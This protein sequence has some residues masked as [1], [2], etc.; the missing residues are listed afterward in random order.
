[1]EAK[2]ILLLASGKAKANA[3]KQLL[4]GEVTAKVPASVLQL[5][6]HVTIIADEEALSETNI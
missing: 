6:H 1:M 2:E 3:I 4:S 5:H